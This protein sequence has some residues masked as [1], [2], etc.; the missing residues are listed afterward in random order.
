[1]SREEATFAALV[2]TAC[3]VAAAVVII[4]HFVLEAAC[5]TFPS[6]C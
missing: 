4:F 6:F 2:A 1:M 5:A 3:V